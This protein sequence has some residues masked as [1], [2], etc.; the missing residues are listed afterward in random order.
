[1]SRVIGYARVSALDPGARQQIAALR[2]AGVDELLLDDGTDAANPRAQL[3]RCLGSLAAGDVLAVYR[4]DRLAQTIAGIVGALHDLSSRG[5]G[6]FAVRDGIDT[7]TSAGAAVYQ[8]VSAA[9]SAVDESAR[10]RAIS[11]AAPREAQPHAGGRPRNLSADLV[12]QGLEFAKQPGV[13]AQTLAS[14]LGISRAALY[15]SYPELV[16]ALRSHRQSSI[17]PLSCHEG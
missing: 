17:A 7:R 15:R 9:T 4:L 6:F 16:D 10:E 5:I 1:M 11:A 2:E 8:F 12:Q 3:H 13:T 14:A